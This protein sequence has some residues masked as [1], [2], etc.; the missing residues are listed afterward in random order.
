MFC[1]KDKNITG[2]VRQ[3]NKD[4]GSL[5]SNILHLFRDQKNVKLVSYAAPFLEM[6]STCHSPESTT[7][8]E[9]VHADKSSPALRMPNCGVRD[10]SLDPMFKNLPR[11]V[12]AE[13]CSQFSLN[14]VSLFYFKHTAPPVLGVPVARTAPRASL[15]QKKAPLNKFAAQ[16]ALHK[17]VTTHK[18]RSLKITLSCCA[19]SRDLLL[20]ILPGRDTAI[21][22]TKNNPG[23]F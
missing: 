22:R 5:L 17:E 1:Q 10:L 14:P 21:H 19:S 13:N 12:C 11:C 2:R 4:S 15:G 18:K 3:Q 6:L 9:R 7:E 20:P 23:L 16:P 8:R